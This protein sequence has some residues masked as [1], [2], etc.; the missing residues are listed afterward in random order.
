MNTYECSICLHI[1]HVAHLHCSTC[2]TIPARYSVLGIASRQLEHN[3]H[4]YVGSWMIESVRAHGAQ[5]IEQRH[6]SR[7][8]LR[9][10]PLDYYAQGE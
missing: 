10:V 3:S 7:S 8:N 4:G 6:S 1:N 2:G 5:S 9:T